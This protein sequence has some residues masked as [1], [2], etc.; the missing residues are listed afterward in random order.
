VSDPAEKR[1][2]ILDTNVLVSAL[3]TPS[4]NPSRI[5]QAVID[6]EIVL[7]HSAAIMAEYRSVL[8]RPR[9]GFDPLDV[10][11]VLEFFE[12]FGDAVH[13]D[14]SE[15]SLPD[16]S[17]RPSYD[18]S[19]VSQAILVTGNIKHFPGLEHVVSPA[20]YVRDHLS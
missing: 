12:S 8:A 5:L 3:L 2:V 15:T 4:G 14:V 16:E 18:A 10:M 6:G 19:L 13:T 20:E 7:V 9:F 11:D 1:R 17:D